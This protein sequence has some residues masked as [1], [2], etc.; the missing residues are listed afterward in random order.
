[1]SKQS[2]KTRASKE[3]SPLP[4]YGF[5]NY[6]LTND[7]KK[8]LKEQGV[9]HERIWD[10]TESAIEA[11]WTFKFS[12]DSYNRSYQVVVAQKY[13]DSPQVGYLLSGRGSTPMKALRQALYIGDQLSWDFAAFFKLQQHPADEIDD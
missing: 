10:S 13:P 11:G 4:F 6:N 12:W 2:T 9:D 8:F 5:I 3:H 7:E 1:M